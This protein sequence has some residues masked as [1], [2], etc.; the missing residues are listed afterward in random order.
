MPNGRVSIA[1]CH[2]VSGTRNSYHARCRKN[3][4][5]RGPHAPPWQPCNGSR[6]QQSQRHVGTQSHLSTADGVHT[7]EAAAAAAAVGPGDL[8]HDCMQTV[9]SL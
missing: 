6:P 4:V 7:A 3:S 9:C 2:I 8:N 5:R 1:G